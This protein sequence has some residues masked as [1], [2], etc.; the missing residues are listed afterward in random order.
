MTD[1]FDAIAELSPLRSIARSGDWAAT[2]EFFAG[3]GS[4]DKVSFA[5]GAL[6][7]I[8][9]TEEYLQKAVQGRPGDPLART[10]LAERYTR[11]GWAIRSGARAKNVSREQFER[12]H[13][14]LRKA[15]Q[16]LIEVCAEHP[17]YAPAWTARLTTARGLQ[18]GQSEARRRYD[19]L[20]AHHPHHV[21]AQSQL[22][23]QVCPKWSGSWEDAHGFA[24]ECL[25]SAPAGSYAGLIVA[26]AHVEHWLDLSGVEGE[27]YLR[28]AAVRNDLRHAARTS[29]LHPDHRPGW[30]EII[31][32]STFAFAYSLGGHLKDA[33]P[34]FAALGNT[35]SESPWYYL[36]DWRAQFTE[37]RTAALET[38]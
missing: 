9:G 10:L 17:D 4:V 15:E 36:R 3:L 11:V 30:H 13:A 19:R 14:W 33:A 5:V 28:D 37:Y 23:Q 35:V 25:S 24:T 8:D 27:A 16:I 38:L 2:E 32:H 7:G 18:L 6:V 22:L 26:E 12:F 21:R 20:A 29:L 34:H 1:P 31:A